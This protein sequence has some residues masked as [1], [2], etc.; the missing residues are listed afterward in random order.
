MYYLLEVVRNWRYILSA[1]PQESE[2]T[3]KYSA[4]HQSKSFVVHIITWKDF[5]NKI[6]KQKKIRNQN[7]FKNMHTKVTHLTPFSWE[8]LKFYYTLNRKIISKSLVS[9]FK[10]LSFCRCW[11]VPSYS[12]DMS[13][14]KLH[15]YSRL[16]WMQMPCWSQ[17]EWNYSEVW[18]WVSLHFSVFIYLID[19]S[20]SQKHT[21]IFN[22]EELYHNYNSLI[23]YESGI[24][25]LELFCIGLYI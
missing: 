25:T 18:R 8:K 14:R 9:M 20:E 23:W 6:L 1:H 19:D 2:H 7:S 13:G 21:F 3:Q 17:A 15:Q 5:K 16:F 10:M 11:W 12:W 22:F 24:I 4:T